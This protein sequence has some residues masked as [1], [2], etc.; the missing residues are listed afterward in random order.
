VG[1]HL[2]AGHRGGTLVLA[3]ATSA[4][5]IG[6]WQPFAGLRTGDGLDDADGFRQQNHSLWVPVGDVVF[7]RGSL[8]DETEDSRR[9]IT[10]ADGAGALGGD[11]LYRDH[12]G[13]QRTVS[14]FTVVP[15]A[16]GGRWWASTSRPV[17]FDEVRL[18]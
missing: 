9:I 1:H 3:A 4:S 17:G 18:A 15:D 7:R 5:V 13:G 11:L 8:R 10:E 14:R 16:D 6:A 2:L 12:E